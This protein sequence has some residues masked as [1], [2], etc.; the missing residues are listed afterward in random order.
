MQ[1]PKFIVFAQGRYRLLEDEDRGILQVTTVIL[2]LSIVD[3]RILSIPVYQSLHA[4][5]AERSSVGQKVS[6][7][8]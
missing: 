2:F 8:L 7:K 5:L 4:V 6:I 3:Q 1:V